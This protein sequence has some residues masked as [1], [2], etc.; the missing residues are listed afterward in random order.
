M[1][2]GLAV[3]QVGSG[4]PLVLIHGI[5]TDS[6]IWTTVVPE[7]ARGRRVITVD[8]PGF[9]GSAPVGEGF[10]LDTVA[11]AIV[12]GLHAEGVTGRYDLVGHSL[13]GGVAITLAAAHPDVVRRLVLVAPAGLRPLPPAVAALLA[14]DRVSRLLAGA[15][16]MFL[17]ARRGAA[18]LTDLAWGRRLL[19][20]LAVADG[21]Q[22]PP[23]VARGLLEAS[24]GSHLS[25]PALATITSVDLRPR[26]GEIAAPLGVIWGVADRTVPIRG[27]EELL[28]ARPDAE[29]VRLP[30]TGHMPMVEC[31]A[32][33][34]TGLHRL[35][36][37]TT[38]PAEAVA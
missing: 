23:A 29:V 25:G 37:D 17:A 8:L 32:A 21:A 31:P 6:R 20:G 18:P 14:G 34:L 35:L 13:G 1:A 19:L 16:D 33:F 36:A 9:G 27:L 28:R 3:A 26:L 15:A 4:A 11:A 38:S 5:A 10:D 24:R 7:L 12:A 2:Q 30:G 22:V